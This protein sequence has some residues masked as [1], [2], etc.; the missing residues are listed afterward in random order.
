[1]PETPFDLYFH[2]KY[3]I[4][5][6]KTQ[7]LPMGGMSMF[8][9]WVHTDRGEPYPLLS[10][11]G[12]G[13]ETVVGGT[14]SFASA[15][16]GKRVRLL[17]QHFPYQTYEL[18]VGAL[19]E[20]AS[21]GF[22]IAARAERGSAYTPET[23]PRLTVTIRREGETVRILRS[24]TIGEEQSEQTEPCEPLPFEQGVY[25]QL[26]SRGKSFDLYVRRGGT[27]S[28]CTTLR[29]DAFAP[30]AAHGTFVNTS[31]ALAVSVPAGGTVTV[32]D[33]TF[34]LDGGVSH[35]DMKPVRYEDGTVVTDHGKVFL[36]MS[37]RL[38]EGGY[39]SVWTLDPSTADLSLIGAIFFDCGDGVWCSDVGTSLLYDR[40]M[41][42]WLLWSVSFSHGHILCHARMKGDVRFGVN[43]VDVTLMD[44]EK[45]TETAADSLGSVSGAVRSFRA[46]LSDDRLWLGK[47]GDEDPDL[48]WDTAHGRWLMTICRVVN[49]NGKNRYRYF[50]FESAEPFTGFRYVAQTDR[51]E[52]TGGLMILWDGDIYFCCGSDFAVHS[53]YYI[54][55]LPALGEPHE[56]RC[57]FPDGGF[58]GWGTVFSV[59]CGSRTRTYWITFDRHGGSSYN[60]S[61]GNLYLYE[62]E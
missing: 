5:P 61:Y 37:S 44:T 32:S 21:A 7:R 1:M 27:V 30:I 57:D 4:N 39:Q 55:K 15:E 53:R 23:A 9:D 6:Y 49:D 13:E 43:I 2:R 36:T 11:T 20:G 56:L 50:L 46:D 29:E 3:S 35:A 19:S 48:I 8:K 10:S 22:E 25:F 41:D 54:F 60:W 45:R 26:G 59:L 17:G 16:G 47:T 14:Y 42:E 24:L 58:R 18:R 31:A 28:Y 40:R 38:H 52:N 12:A 51:G 62:A 34:F 33:V